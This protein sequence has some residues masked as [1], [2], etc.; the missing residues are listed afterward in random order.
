[1]NVSVSLVNAA[2]AKTED[3]D[4]FPCQA[5]MLVGVEGGAVILARTI[6]YDL[7]FGS[8]C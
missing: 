8:L 6:K 5:T 1:M 2:N 4:G 7:Y 3:A